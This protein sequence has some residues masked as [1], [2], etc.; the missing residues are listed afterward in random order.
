MPELESLQPIEIMVVGS[1]RLRLLDEMIPASNVNTG[2]CIFAYQHDRFIDI[3]A[4]AV[5]V[6]DSRFGLSSDGHIYV[7]QGTSFDYEDAANPG[8]QL[9]ITFTISMGGQTT[10]HTV[11]I[12]ITDVDENPVANTSNIIHGTEGNDWLHGRDGADIIYG[13]S[14]DDDLFGKKGDDKI[15][16]GDGHDWLYGGKGADLVE[17]GAGG[18]WLYGG[19]GN[20]ELKGGAG[21][22]WLFGD[23]GNDKL[24]G[25]DGNDFLI[26]D[27]GENTLTGGAGN[28]KFFIYS[29]GMATVLDF[30]SG[31]DI[32]RLANAPTESVSIEAFQA[33]TGLTWRVNNG[34]TDFY[35]RGAKVM[36]LKDYTA[37][38]TLADF[39][40]K[41]SDI[42]VIYGTVRDDTLNGSD[43]NDVIFALA[44]K[45]TIHGNGGDDEIY[46]DDGFDIIYG[47]DGDDVIYGGSGYNRV[48][49]GAGQD[50]IH[51]GDDQ[52]ELRG[53]DEHDEI[54]GGKSD[55]ALFGEGGGDWLHG[56]EGSD[57]LYGGANNDYLVG[58]AG[59]DKFAFFYKGVEHE[60]DVI[61]DFNPDEGDTIF[62]F[63]DIDISDAG[64]RTLD[65]VKRIAGI[66]WYQETNLDGVT[67][68]IIKTANGAV[69]VE[70]QG[71][72]GAITLDTFGITP[73]PPPEPSVPPKPL[74]N[75]IYGTDGDDELYWHR[76]A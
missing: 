16:G 60:C 27:I 8:G 71:Y 55:D 33:S 29:G 4:D 54:M 75:V 39:D 56:G 24:Y 37:P 46:G 3:P 18:D 43:A 13:H 76:G 42:N 48:Y 17:G 45:D 68:T 50:I 51:G 21:N 73:A 32:L 6:S 22:D 5:T 11:D 1:Q 35:L 74:G 65:D 44:G 31:E 59:A 38:I 20:D 23:F 12:A 63:G 19:D 62:L 28:D 53:G 70:L 7:K 10:S 72:S 64:I 66:D 47:G 41:L 40:V 25:G 9:S 67:S 58:G 49:G 15:F 14:G 52:D 34:N 2:L 69:E 36:Q 26:G 30:T 57:F 61:E